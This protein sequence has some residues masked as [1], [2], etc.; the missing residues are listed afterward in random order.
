MK[1]Q[2]TTQEINLIKSIAS[3]YGITPLVFTKN[4]YRGLI[5]K[6]RRIPLNSKMFMDLLNTTNEVYIGMDRNILCLTI[7]AQ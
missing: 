4:T 1:S 7:V 5:P 2:F 6:N 3:I